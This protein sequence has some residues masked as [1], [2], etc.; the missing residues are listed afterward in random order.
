M[1]KITFNKQSVEVIRW[2]TKPSWVQ[3][4]ML[5]GSEKGM[6]RPARCADET[7]GKTTHKAELDGSGLDKILKNL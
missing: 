3:I 4:E 6:R 7:M 2:L 1:K 5:E